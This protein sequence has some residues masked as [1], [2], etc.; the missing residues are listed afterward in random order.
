MVATYNFALWIY[1]VMPVIILSDRIHIWVRLL[2]TPPV[3]R[4][5]VPSGTRIQSPE[6]RLLYLFQFKFSEFYVSIVLCLLEEKYTFS[7]QEAATGIINRLYCFGSSLD[8]SDKLLEISLNT[9]LVL[10]IYW[11]IHV[12]QG[13]TTQS[14]VAF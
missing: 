12:S 5:I 13:I 8:F 10:G 1:L 2:M 6:R 4:S 3:P 11:T 7:I 9:S 14:S